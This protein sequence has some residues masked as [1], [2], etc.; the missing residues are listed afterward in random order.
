[1][2]HVDLLDGSDAFLAM[3]KRH[4]TDC[5]LLTLLIANVDEFACSRRYVSIG[6]TF[7][8][9]RYILILGALRDQKMLLR[10]RL[11]GYGARLAYWGCDADTTHLLIELVPC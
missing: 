4:G 7:I 1:M 2:A 11:L 8:P 10:G 5:A 6:L 3:L 9:H